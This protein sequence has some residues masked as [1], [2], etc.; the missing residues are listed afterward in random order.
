MMLFRWLLEAYDNLASH[1]V[2]DKHECLVRLLFSPDSSRE[3]DEALKA[4]S[5]LVPFEMISEADI[6]SAPHPLIHSE[7]QS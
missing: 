7:E 3:L 2:L 4:I 1:T 5:S 6:P